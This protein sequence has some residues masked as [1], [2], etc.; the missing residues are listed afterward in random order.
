MVIGSSDILNNLNNEIQFQNLSQGTQAHDLIYDL[1]NNNPSFRDALFNNI[2]EFKELFFVSGTGSVNYS[3]N[4]LNLATVVTDLNNYDPVFLQATTRNNFSGGENAMVNWYKL[5]QPYSFLYFATSAD[6]SAVTTY[7]TNNTGLYKPSGTPLSSNGISFYFNEIKTYFGQ[8]L[9]DQLLNTFLS[10]SNL[11]IDKLMVNEWHIYGSSRIGIYQTSIN[12]AYRNVRIESGTITTEYSTSVAMPSYTLFDIQ[13]GSKRYE[14]TNHLGNVL[15]VVS[16]K[17]IQVCSTNVVSYYMADVVTANDYSPGGAP[18]VGR[19]YTAPNTSYRFG[20]NKGSEKDDEI[21]G[22]GNHFTTLFREGDTRL[23]IWWGIDP[24]ADEQPYQSPY[25]YMDGNPVKY[26]DP[27]GDCPWCI[28]A[29]IGGLVG[30][31]V[32]YGGQVAGN[33]LGGG[34][35][36]ELKTWTNIDFADVGIAAGEGAIIGLTGGLGAAG[37]LGKTAIKVINVSTKITSATSQ[38]LVDVKTDVNGGSQNVFNGTKSN[39]DA[40]AD[41]AM[42]LIGAAFGGKAAT[43]SK[44][45]KG[46]LPDVKSPKVKVKEARLAGPVNTKQRIKIETKAK[47]KQKAVNIANETIKKGGVPGAALENIA[48]DNAKK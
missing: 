22:E 23:L 25:S 15:V 35:L 33:T 6:V 43:G 28:T 38:G 8:S 4:Q 40:I 34:S 1:L 31:A 3:G 27:N 17:K 2:S 48:S 37:K 10:S 32:E 19:S 24:E 45:I 29:A 11:Y 5:N 42:N 18:L 39:K 16:D 44:K 46:L 47:V 7:Q 41:G 12:M 21:S 20:F 13:R 9:V 14:L 30:A 26:N 36:L